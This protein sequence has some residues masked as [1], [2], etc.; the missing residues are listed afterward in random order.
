M[1]QK[2]HYLIF[3]L[4]LIYTFLF[5]TGSCKKDDGIEDPTSITDAR[6]GNVY[7]II[8]IG[9]QMWMAENLKYLPSVTGQGTG[10]DTQPYYYVYGYDGTDVNAAKATDNYQTYGVLYNW[11]AA[12]NA[13]PAGWHLPTD[14]E[15]A[16]LTDFL[17]GESVAGGKLKEEGL[18]H[19]T[20]P[21]EG[22][23]NETDFTALPGGCRRSFG[24]F[25]YLGSNGYWWS[26]TEYDA[27]DAWNRY[28]NYNNGDVH[29]YQSS[30]EEGFSIRCIR[31]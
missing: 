11:P 2:T 27:S 14:A 31:D 16:E 1:K 4:L 26:S 20:N 12:V 6:D 21:N 13:C 17:G 18:S 19:W 28:L 3:S 22:A 8:K 7:K 9:N 5:F 24:S 15:W 30:K 10:S 29:R 25:S 23:T